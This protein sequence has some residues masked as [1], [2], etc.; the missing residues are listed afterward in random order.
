MHHHEGKEEDGP[1][2]IQL[3]TQSQSVVVDVGGSDEE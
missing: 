2:V 1:M 3:A